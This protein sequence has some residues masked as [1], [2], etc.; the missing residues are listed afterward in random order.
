MRWRSVSA[1]RSTK[2]LAQ[3]PPILGELEHGKRGVGGAHFP[4]LRG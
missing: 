2:D 1:T 4:E 3:L